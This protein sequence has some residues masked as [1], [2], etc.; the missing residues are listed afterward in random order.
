MSQTSGKILF[1]DD[2][3]GLRRSLKIILEKSG[4]TVDTAADGPTGLKMF[5]ENEYDLVIHDLKMPGM[6][7]IQLLGELMKRETGIPVVVVTAYSTWN[8]AVEAM[9]LGAYGYLPKPFD[10]EDVR[11]LVLRALQTRHLGVGSA[12]SA[13]ADVLTSLRMIGSTPK[14]QEILRLVR[15]VAA[16][17]STVIIQ[18]E[19][20]TGKELIARLVHLYSLRRESAFIGVNCGAISETLLESEIFGHVR[21]AFTSAVSDKQGLLDLSSGGTFFLDEVGEMSLQTQV[22]FLRVLETKTYMPVGGTTPKKADVRIVAATKRDLESMVENRTFREDLFYRLNVIPVHLPALRERVDDIPLLAGHFLSIYSNIVGRSM[23]GFT[24][25]AMEMLMN[26]EWPGNIRELQN[27]IQ[28]AVT[29]ATGNKI[30]AA[31]VQPARRISEPPST[32]SFSRVPAMPHPAA[33]SQYGATAS[34]IQPTSAPAYEIPDGRFNLELKLEEIEGEYIRSA[35]Q[36]TDGNLTRAAEMLGI[37]FRSI[38]YKVKK[39][40]LDR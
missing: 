10:N 15:R 38:R 4:H 33:P 27:T 1:V 37:T 32:V 2:D 25:E 40:G 19:S 26:W 17:D 30:E 13:A 7:G 29:L 34:G 11:A 28:R 9:R 16:T 23:E 5:D 24:D 20:G 36:K 8:T 21:G 18:G 12:S 31:D 39:L 22:A 3:Q 6:D 35:L 14:I